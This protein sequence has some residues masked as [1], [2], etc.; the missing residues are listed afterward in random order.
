[1]IV[2][3]RIYK[4]SPTVDF[5]TFDYYFFQTSDV[6]MQGDDDYSDSDDIPL[7][8]NLKLKLLYKLISSVAFLT[9]SK[10]RG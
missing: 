8:V 9:G 3:Y 1:M 6:Y 5:L 2:L 4:Y 10:D 7:K